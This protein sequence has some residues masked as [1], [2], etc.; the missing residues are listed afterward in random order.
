MWK[1]LVCIELAHF[2]KPKANKLTKK[3]KE[4]KNKKKQKKKNDQKQRKAET[5][6]F[7]NTSPSSFSP[8]S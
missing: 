7:Y 6:F 8:Y 2:F 4:L 3:R 1:S 5:R